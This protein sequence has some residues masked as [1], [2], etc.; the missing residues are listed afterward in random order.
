MFLGFLENNETI[1]WEYAFSSEIGRKNNVELDYSSVEYEI[2]HD[3]ISINDI[4]S[5]SNEL[6]AFKIQTRFDF[7]LKLSSVIRLC[8]GLSANQL[9]Q[10][11]EAKAIFM[12]EDCFV[13]K[14]K[15][16]NG[17][18]VLIS[19]EKLKASLRIE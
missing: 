13:K 15:V 17:D 14:R 4:L 3:N 2:L 8:L 11:I 9:N 12:A 16:K 19:K 7:E 1:A 5:T 6:I 18:V 10:M